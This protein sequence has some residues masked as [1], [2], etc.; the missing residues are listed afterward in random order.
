MLKFYYKK[1]I[2]ALLAVL[3]LFICMSV[4]SCFIFASDITSNINEDMN[5]ESYIENIYKDAID[6][7]IQSEI[8][9]SETSKQNL[10]IGT[11][12]IIKNLDSK[13][14]GIWYCPIIY[15]ENVVALI[16]VYKNGGEFAFSITQEY[17]EQINLVSNLKEVFFFSIDDTVYLMN[18]EEKIYNVSYGQLNECKLDLNTKDFYEYFVNIYCI[19]EKCSIYSTNTRGIK[20]SNVIKDI[21][22]GKE[23]WMDDCFVRQYNYPICWA[24]SCATIIRYKNTNYVS[25]GL[26]A[27]DV[28]YRLAEAYGESDAIQGGDIYDEQ[29]AMALYGV[30]YTMLERKL[31]YQEVKNAI[32]TGNP[33]LINSRSI[34][35]NDKGVMEAHG[36]AVVIYGYYSNDQYNYYKLWNPAT[37]TIQTMQYTPGKELSFFFNNHNFYWNSTVCNGL[38]IVK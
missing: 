30:Y 34:Y 21:T 14:S 25:S 35:E 37:G 1:N 8:I 22:N 27:F 20:K 16:V 12:F 36:H 26:N 2:K 13:N 38:Y 17:V 31:S 33:F 29:Y 4:N 19:N 7:G 11:E 5:V 10:L 32:N 3:I 24:A 28:A 9:D 23:C 18:S 15:D 6:I